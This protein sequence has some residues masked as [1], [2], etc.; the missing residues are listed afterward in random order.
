MP[1]AF[2]R[3]TD[4][5]SLQLLFQQPLHPAMHHRAL[6]SQ[7][8]S[9]GVTAKR[10]TE[11]WNDYLKFLQVHFSNSSHVQCKF[12]R[13]RDVSLRCKTVKEF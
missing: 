6:Y 10:V 11:N 13:K 12:G 2:H 1:P 3:L 5:P 7:A 8:D 9:A 4:R